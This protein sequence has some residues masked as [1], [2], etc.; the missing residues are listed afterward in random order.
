MENSDQKPSRGLMLNSTKES[1][2]WHHEVNSCPQ[3]HFF[4]KNLHVQWS[5]A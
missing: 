5:K 1:T 3:I 2:S 4:V